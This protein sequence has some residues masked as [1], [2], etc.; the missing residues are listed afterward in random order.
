MAAAEVFVDAGLS[1]RPN[2]CLRSVVTWTFESQSGPALI[3]GHRARFY[4][5]RIE[6][7]QRRS[8]D[9]R[10]DPL[11]ATPGIVGQIDD[12]LRIGEAFCVV[13]QVESA[14]DS[15]LLE[16]GDALNP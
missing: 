13:I 2:P 9:R 7:T 15:L 8:S 11:F 12:I 4:N 10:F 16:I 3:C 5:V 14:G 6:Q 1:S